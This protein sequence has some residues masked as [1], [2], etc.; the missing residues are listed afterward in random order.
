MLHC[1]TDSRNIDC[2]CTTVASNDPCSA[3]AWS[4]A[5]Y[6]QHNKKRATIAGSDA[7]QPLPLPKAYIMSHWRE[8][9]PVVPGREQVDLGVRGHDP[10][11]VVLAP[12]CL[13]ARPLGHVPHADALVLAVA[14]DD[15]LRRMHPRARITTPC[16]ISSNMRSS[17]LVMVPWAPQRPAES[18][19]GRLGHQHL[20]PQPA[21]CMQELELQ[22]SQGNQYLARVEHD[23]G[24]VVD[25]PPQRV[26]LPRLGVC[27]PAMH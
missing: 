11:A 27:A 23:A 9:A 10:E 19:Q 15:V 5:A 14:H 18:A 21:I 22:C 2:I 1:W 3:S 8:W 6:P 20:W 17:D 4:I 16:C 26:H 25:V 13:H 12:E 24:D 7:E